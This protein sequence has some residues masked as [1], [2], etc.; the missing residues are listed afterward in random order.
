MGRP[1]RTRT[2]LPARSWRSPRPWWTRRPGSS[3]RSSLRSR[4]MDRCRRATAGRGRTRLQSTAATR[5]RGDSPG[6][7]SSR[8]VLP[9]LEPRAS[10]A[11]S[12]LPRAA[13]NLH[14]TCRAV[15]LE[16]G[17]DGSV[18]HRSDGGGALLLLRADR[19]R[20]SRRHRPVLYGNRGEQPHR[21]ALRLC[22]LP[23]AH[24]SGVGG[25]SPLLRRG[26]ASHSRPEPG[27]VRG[28]AG[29]SPPGRR[30]LREAL[31]GAA[32]GG[33]VWIQPRRRGSGMAMVMV[34]PRRCPAFRGS[35]VML[36]PPSSGSATLVL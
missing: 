17:R 11:R 19:V 22:G 1:D 28:S 24:R 8:R 25:R 4:P 29:W 35:M 32:G 7:P 6:H 33:E 9:L 2:S 18:G 14:G 21:L 20:R 27:S 10:T 26:R 12:Q 36:R 31:V 23:S 15:A 3:G 5:L 16:V 30:G 34:R 13:V